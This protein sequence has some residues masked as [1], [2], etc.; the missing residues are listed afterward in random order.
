MK[1]EQM[2]YCLIAFILGW[3]ISRQMGNGFSVGGNTNGRCYIN[4][5]AL[6]DYVYSDENSQKKNLDAYTCA[7]HNN[8]DDCD[9][10]EDCVWREYGKIPPY[11]NNTDDPNIKEAISKLYRDPLIFDEKNI[12]KH[13]VEG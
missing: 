7:I 10:I 2:L 13:M 11:Y 3:L 8:Q 1:E 6:V 5:S 12:L 4:G 9:D